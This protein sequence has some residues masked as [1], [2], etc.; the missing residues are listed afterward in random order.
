MN[1]LLRIWGLLFAWGL[2]GSIGWAAHVPMVLDNRT[3][4]PN[5]RTVQLFRGDQQLT[6]PMLHLNDASFLSLNFDVIHNKPDNLYFTVIHC[7]ADW[8]QSNLFPIQ[9]LE[10]ME[11]S[12]IQ[13]VQLSRATRV[14]YVHYGARIPAP[15]MR[16][17]HSGNYLLLVYRGFD[18]QDLILTRR[19]IVVEPGVR[20]VPNLGLTTNTAQRFRLQQLEFDIYPQALSSQNPLFDYRVA[21]MQNFRWDNMQ[22]NLQP[23]YLQ[24][25]RLEYRFDAAGVFQGGNEFRMFDIRGLM[26]ARMGL[27]GTL[28]SDTINSAVLLPDKPRTQNAYA[29]EPDLNGLFFIATEM[30]GISHLEADY[31]WTVFTLNM[32]N[33]LPDADVYVFGAMTDWRAA[34]HSKMYW[35]APE[36]RYETQMLLKQGLY[37]YQYVTL[38]NTAPEPIA[39]GGKGKGKPKA[40]P[41]PRPD[42]ARLEGSHFETENFYTI[43]V[44]YR[45]PGDQGDRLVG[46]QHVNF[47]EQ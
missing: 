21:V 23:L 28:L 12:W 29:S 27:A 45:A 9:Y 5:V 40:A 34:P 41:A 43:L 8:T 37:N 32:P 6:P 16:F 35:N 36:R 39:Q 17:K 20:I 10:G 19:F 2:L 46:M 14:H 13:D 11:D 44:Y 42:E 7:N 22:Q 4:E 33:P 15:G 38:P 31:V 18:K 24:H 30:A 26:G 3:Y 1:C 47:Y 25:D